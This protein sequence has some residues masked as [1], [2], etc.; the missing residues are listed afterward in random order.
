MAQDELYYLENPRKMREHPVYA[1]ILALRGFSNSFAADIEVM[2]SAIH[3]HFMSLRPNSLPLMELK[4]SS[5]M[6]TRAVHLFW[7]AFFKYLDKN[8]TLPLHVQ[9]TALMVGHV[10]ERD[11]PKVL[12]H[13][14]PAVV[15]RYREFT[16]YGEVRAAI[17]SRS[18]PFV[19]T[20]TAIPH[21]FIILHVSE[22]IDTS[23]NE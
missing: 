18:G 22:R 2:E 8:W 10:E 14:E 13:F 21:Y 12:P 15:K 17:T 19:K 20:N 4:M 1:D 9:E 16:R 5:I 11:M 3:D 23:N 6:T 7:D